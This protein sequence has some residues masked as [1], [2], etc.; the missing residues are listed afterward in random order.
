[1]HSDRTRLELELLV[2]VQPTDICFRLFPLILNASLSGANT[3]CDLATLPSSFESCTK[4]VQAEMCCPGNQKT[5]YLADCNV[6]VNYFLYNWRH[7]SFFCFAVHAVVYLGSFVQH[8]ALAH[9]A[10][11]SRHALGSSGIAVRNMRDAQ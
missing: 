3:E 6:T 2:A 4:R 10:L 9:C 11:F 1:M 5:N 8:C 7:Q